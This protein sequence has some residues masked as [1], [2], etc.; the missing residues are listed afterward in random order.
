LEVYSYLVDTSWSQHLKDKKK[1]NNFICLWLL[2]QT[3]MDKYEQFEDI[4]MKNPQPH[5]HHKKEIDYFTKTIKR[6]SSEEKWAIALISFSVV[7][8]IVHLV[9]ACVS[10]N[11]A[12][13]TKWV[14]K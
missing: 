5:S 8:L 7:L 14:I 6:G 2:Q 1:G 9:T 11:Y 3:D 4:Y 12:Y 13:R 10:K